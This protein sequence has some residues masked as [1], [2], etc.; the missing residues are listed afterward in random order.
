[1]GANYIAHWESDFA[2]RDGRASFTVCSWR[3]S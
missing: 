1:M 3:Q 2:E